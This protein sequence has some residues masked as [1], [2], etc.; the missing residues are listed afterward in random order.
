MRRYS[1]NQRCIGST[2]RRTSPELKKCRYFTGMVR[3]SSKFVAA[4]TR[5]AIRGKSTVHPA[6]NGSRM[7]IIRFL[8]KPAGPRCSS[9]SAAKK[10]AMT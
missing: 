7:R 2:W 5:A 10:P 6:A 8:R 4:V 1:R 9:R 3:G